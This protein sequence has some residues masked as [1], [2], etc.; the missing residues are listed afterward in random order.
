MKK[1]FYISELLTVSEYAGWLYGKKIMLTAP[2][3]VGKTTFILAELLPYCASLG[4][5]VVILCNRRLLREQYLYDLAEQYKRYNQM[6]NDI[7]IMTY[8]ALAEQIKQGQSMEETLKEIDLIVCDES[9]YFYADSDFNAYGTFVLLQMLVAC[10]IR[11]SMVFITATAKEVTP[12][13]ENT[14]RL[15]ASWLRIS[16]ETL[17]LLNVYDFSN[18][19]DYTRFDAYYVEDRE[20]LLHQIATSEKKTLI[21]IDDKSKAEGMK[22]RLVEKEKLKSNDIYMLNSELLDQKGNDIVIKSLAITH[23]ILP[24]ILITTSVLDNGIS[25]HDAD[26]GNVV[27][28]ADAEI[29]FVQMLGRIRSESGGYVRLYFYPR[30]NRYFERRLEQTQKKL[31]QFKRLEN[32]MKQLYTTLPMQLW[33]DDEKFG[34]NAI[35]LAEEDNLFYSQS[36]LSIRILFGGFVLAVNEFAKEKVGNEYLMYRR[37]LKAALS[38]AEEFVKIQMSWIKMMPEELQIVKSTYRVER[39]AE[40][41]RKLLSVK[42]MTNEAMQT[43][44][45]ELANEFFD[46]IGDIIMKKQSFSKVKLIAVCE[47]FNLRVDEKTANGKKVYS[48]VED[49]VER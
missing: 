36:N 5:K 43:M 13:I 35:V 39:E 9:H 4:K 48:I 18:L 29:A 6:E 34:R 19:A 44:K 49:I 17:Y 38:S 30:E 21:F 37:F 3:G 12:L 20:T 15:C 27:L 41:R 26:V 11:K 47:R 33:D 1:K 25:I 42:N 14:L 23:R 28:A 40:L 2:T 10:S 22:K 32:N 24:K 8:Q 16:D 7:S 31:D 46:L 45:E